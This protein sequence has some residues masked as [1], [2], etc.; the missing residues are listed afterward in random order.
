MTRWQAFVAW[1]GL[2]LAVVLLALSAAARSPSIGSLAVLLGF[3]SILA[4]RAR[5]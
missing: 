3:L 4:L 5:D 2:A 1:T